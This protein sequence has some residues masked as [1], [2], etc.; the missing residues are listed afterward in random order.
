MPSVE[1]LECPLGDGYRTNAETQ[2]GAA[3]RLVDHYVDKH[4]GDL[5]PLIV[6]LIK[7]LTGHF[8]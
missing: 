1:Q 4:P 2:E 7:G 6:N 8:K 3:A 5:P